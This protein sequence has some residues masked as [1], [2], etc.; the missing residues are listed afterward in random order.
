MDKRTQANLSMLRSVQTFEARPDILAATI[1]IPAIKLACD[2]LTAT[3]DLIENLEEEAAAASR[4]DG[5]NKAGLR[6]L[7]TTTGLIADG[8]ITAWAARRGLPDVIQLFNHE[9]SD[10]TRASD[11]DFRTLCARILAK[12]T[13]CNEIAPDVY[14]VTAKIARVSHIDETTSEV[15]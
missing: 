3:I 15:S 6:K 13:E 10:F 1:G 7:T 9:L 2:E 4:G 5:G 12:V 14:Q 11:E 8:K